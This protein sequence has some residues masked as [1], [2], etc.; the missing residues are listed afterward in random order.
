MTHAIDEIFTKEQ[1]E[2]LTP[3]AVIAAL[4]AG[5]GRYVAGDRTAWD[6]RAQIPKAAGGQH[7]MAIVLSCVDSRVLVEEVFDCGIGDLFV[8]R[9]AGNFVNTDM[10]GSMEFACAVSGSKVV[11]V[12]GH[13]SCGAVKSTID[14]ADLGN[15]TPMLKNI[16]P[17]VSAVDGFDDRTTNNPDFVHAVVEKNVQL[18]LA[19]IRAESPALAELEAENK[20]K[21]VGAVY[22]LDDGSVTFL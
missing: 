21:I 1:Q 13:Q 10:L 16:A 5:N 11:V 2:A 18:T 22:S 19:R 3:D 8:A 15:I 20:I 7:P 14:G 4:Q 12:L 9:V 6:H 17:A